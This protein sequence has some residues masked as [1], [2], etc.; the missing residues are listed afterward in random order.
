MTIVN[1]ITI[2]KKI[3]LIL[4]LILNVALLCVIAWAVV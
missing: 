1:S 4:S 3:Y 2:M